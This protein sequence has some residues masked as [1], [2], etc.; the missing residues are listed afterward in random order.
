MLVLSLLDETQR[1]D[2]TGDFVS[3]TEGSDMSGD[4]N[5]TD[6]TILSEVTVLVHI[7]TQNSKSRDQ[8][9]NSTSYSNPTLTEAASVLCIDSYGLIM[10]SNRE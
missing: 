2:S 3:I 10:N 6:G 7:K 5:G 8:Q 1:A 9:R 4:E